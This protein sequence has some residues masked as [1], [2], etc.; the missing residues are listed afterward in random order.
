[1]KYDLPRPSASMLIIQC[2]LVLACAVCLYL[3]LTAFQTKKN[4]ETAILQ[5]NQQKQSLNQATKQLD[6]YLKFISEEP[7]FQRKSE[8]PQWEKT[9]E[10]W[11]EISYDTLLQRLSKL[12]RPDRPFVLDFFSASLKGETADNA[13]SKTDEAATDHLN[14]EQQSQK[15][16]FNLQGY[17]LC[18]C[19]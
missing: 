16:V 18:P 17:F 14:G 12:Y 10:V 13:V 3:F 15:L 2:S 5:L 1:M 7:F 4:Y 11:V 19:K 9:D 6:R 8:E